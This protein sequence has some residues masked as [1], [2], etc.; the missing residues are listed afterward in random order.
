MDS[1]R[2]EEQKE[3]ED[4]MKTGFHLQVSG[5]EFTVLLRPNLEAFLRKASAKYDLILFTASTEEYTKEIL[6]K[7]DP[8]N[9]FFKGY[10]FREHCTPFIFQNQKIYMKDLRLI[11]RFL[12]RVV[13]VDN[14]IANLGFQPENGI[15]ITSFLGDLEDNALNVLLQFLEGIEGFSDVRNYLGSIFRLK[16]YFEIPMTS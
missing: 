11:N 5:H 1:S 16:R 9:R 8:Q 12:G 2:E 14:T 3:E 7:I 15:P 13:L 6:K 10:F 4:G